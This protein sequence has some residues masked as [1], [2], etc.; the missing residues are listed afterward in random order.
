MAPPEVTSPGIPTLREKA[1]GSLIGLGPPG[2]SLTPWPMCPQEWVLGQLPV[3]VTPPS[4]CPLPCPLSSQS[5]SSALSPEPPTSSS[6]P[7]QDGASLLDRKQNQLHDNKVHGPRGMFC[8]PSGF[9]QELREPPKRE[10]DS[11]WKNCQAAS[12]PHPI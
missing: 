7:S 11:F 3:T 4:F 5:W 9:I 1:D 10:T 6:P 12:M 8:G 2:S